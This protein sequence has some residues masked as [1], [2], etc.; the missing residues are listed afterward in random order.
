MSEKIKGE[1]KKAKGKRQKVKGNKAIRLKGN[2][3]NAK[4]KK[5]IANS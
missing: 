4:R 3:Y 1:S 5:L 2:E